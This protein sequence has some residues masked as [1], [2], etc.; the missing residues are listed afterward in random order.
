MEAE[1]TAAEVATVEEAEAA[2]T[3]EV[4]TAE[5]VATEAEDT[6][7]FR[8]KPINLY[9]NVKHDVVTVLVPKRKHYGYGGGYG[10]GHGHGGYAGSIGY[11]R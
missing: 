1:G 4:A 3:E 8:P 7:H 5:A 11:Y 9:Q 10:H 6:V 2:A